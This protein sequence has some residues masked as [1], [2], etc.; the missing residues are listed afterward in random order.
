MASSLNFSKGATLSFAKRPTRFTIG[1]EWQ[2]AAGGAKAAF[3]GDLVAVILGAGGKLIDDSH[4]IYF[5][6]RSSP[7]GAVSLSEDNRTGAD[8]FVDGVDTFD[9]EIAIDLGR[10][11]AATQID[12]YAVIYDG[13]A[14]GQD[15]SMLK[16]VATVL[17]A[18]SRQVIGS[19]DLGRDHKGMTSVQIG[20]LYRA[21][22]EWELKLHGTGHALDHEAIYRHYAG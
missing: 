15:W 4:Y 9:E 19:F 21:G 18:A 1:L 8:K 17:D 3:D 22:G 16:A 10:L 11:A 14:R 12:L 6:Q 20:S 7:D 5:R 13:A 2:E